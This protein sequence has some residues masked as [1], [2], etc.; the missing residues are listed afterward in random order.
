MK[1]QINNE[2]KPNPFL[3]S[4]YLINLDIVSPSNLKKI[5]ERITFSPTFNLNKTVGLYTA[6]TMYATSK[7]NENISFFSVENN[8]KDNI[9]KNLSMNKDSD[10]KPSLSSVE[11]RN[12]LF[13]YSKSKKYEEDQLHFNNKTFTLPDEINEEDLERQEFRKK[14]DEILKN[15]P[16]PLENK[17]DENFKIKAMAKMRSE[18]KSENKS[19]KQTEINERLSHQEEFRISIKL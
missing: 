12:R 4:N 18:R 3:H 5:N 9:V 8:I 2:E 13:E 17:N 7:K 14:I 10:I 1:E 6:E 19:A 16:V 15:L 11:S